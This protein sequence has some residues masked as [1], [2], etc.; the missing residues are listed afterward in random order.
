MK[1]KDVQIVSEGC[2]FTG[3]DE[4]LVSELIGAVRGITTQVPGLTAFRGIVVDSCEGEQKPHFRLEFVGPDGA[5]DEC[6]A[7]KLYTLECH[8]EISSTGQL[9]GEVL[10]DGEVDYDGGIQ[11]CYVDQALIG[12]EYDEDLETSPCDI[13]VEHGTTRI[14]FSGAREAVDLLIVMYLFRVYRDTLRK[15]FPGYSTKFD[16]ETLK[17]CDQLTGAV[18]LFTQ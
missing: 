11:V 7:K 15:D 6:A 10:A 2:I 1:V 9:K 8:P 18:Y 13:I 5:G 14:V 3:D 12:G 16:T 17:S 4:H